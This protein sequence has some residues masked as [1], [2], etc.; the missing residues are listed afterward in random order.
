[1]KITGAMQMS[2]APVT[3]FSAGALTFCEKTEPAAAVKTP[4]L[5]RARQAGRFVTPCAA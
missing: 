2:T 3:F 1:M 5:A 4:V